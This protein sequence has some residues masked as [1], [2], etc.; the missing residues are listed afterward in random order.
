VDIHTDSWWE[1]TLVANV[2][3]CSE[4]EVDQLARERKLRKVIENETPLYNPDDVEW[5]LEQTEDSHRNLLFSTA[6]DLDK[7]IESIEFINQPWL[8]KG[9]VTLLV[10][11]PGLGKSM[12]ALDVTR[13]VLD[14]ELGWF[15]DQ[16]LEMPR[17]T[18]VLWL[19]T[20]AFQ[21]GLKERIKVLRIPKDRVIFPFQN[22][23][24]DVRLDDDKHRGQIESVIR[25]VKPSLVVVDSLRGSHGKDENDSRDMTQILS[26]LSRLA[27]DYNIAILVIHHVRK[28]G[29]GEPD[30]ISL[31]RQRGSSATAYLA[32]TVWGLERPN[33][34]SDLLRLRVIKSNVARIP[35]PVGL[36]TTDHGIEWSEEVPDQP[37]KKTKEEEAKEFIHEALQDGPRL[38]KDLDEEAEQKGIA[39]A[40][41]RRAS[42]HLGVMKEKRK[43]DG[44]WEWTLLPEEPKRGKSEST[45]KSRK[46]GSGKPKPGTPKGS[47]LT[48]SDAPSDDA[49]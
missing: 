29:P 39:K 49:D 36:K 18:K 40:T 46:S 24:E 16:P 26:F 12:L 5:L 37:R 31:T 8:P 2:L 25:E 41:F 44:L 3:G 9:L 43:G 7:S 10:A 22:P 14:P 38:I 33:P 20:E 42:E 13:R 1:R 4:Q 17:M 48:P 15:N 6:E 47:S 19:E 34:E 32:R 11:S 27:R 35:D 30:I 28:P 21:A 45:P 23:L